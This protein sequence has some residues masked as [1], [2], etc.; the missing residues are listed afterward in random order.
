MKDTD[1]KIIAKVENTY[2]MLLNGIMFDKIDRVKHKISPNIYNYYKDYIENLKNKNLR[3]M[4]EEPNIKS[5]KIIQRKQVNGFEEVSIVL[6][7]RYIEY[8]ADYQN[9]SYISGN[10][11]SR[12]TK[13]N[14]LLFTKKN[15]VIE[16]RVKS[17]SSCGANIDFNNNGI[18]SYCHT[19][20][21]TENH[22]YILIEINEIK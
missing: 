8:L 18:C 3:Q 5:I 19:T 12:I 17:C 21:D 9:N 6:T 20:Y 13:E 4:Y 1:E 2:I 22:D 10:N 11:K 7:S 14:H 16:E 15:S